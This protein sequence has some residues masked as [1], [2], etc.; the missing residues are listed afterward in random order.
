VISAVK[1]RAVFHSISV[2]PVRSMVP[3]SG[4]APMAACPYPMVVTPTPS[5]AD[6]DV[7]RCRTDWHSFYNRRRHWRLADDWSRS[8]DDRGWNRNGDW[9]VDSEMNS[10][11]YSCD[12]RSCQNQNCNCLFHN[13]YLT[14]KFDVRG[15]QNIVTRELRFCKSVRGTPHP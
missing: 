3:V 15:V 8:H 11:V 14:I 6:P 10:G 4:R 1:V 2:A 5:P 12:S 13:V 7:S 9:E